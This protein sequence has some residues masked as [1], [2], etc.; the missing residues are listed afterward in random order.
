[1]A[2]KRIS[3]TEALV[4]SPAGGAEHSISVRQIDNGHIVRQST[5]NPST[6]QYSC[7]ERYHERAPKITGPKVRGGAAP[8]AG[9]P[10][11]GAMALLKD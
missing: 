7:S 1:M 11:R 9:N 10:L 8:D 5:Y 6:G 2:R 3:D 4:A